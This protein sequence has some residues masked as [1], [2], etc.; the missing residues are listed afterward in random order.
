MAF[1]K[2][3]PNLQLSSLWLCAKG[4]KKIIISTMSRSNKVLGPMFCFA[5]S[6][7]ICNA[8]SN[9]AEILISNMSECSCFMKQTYCGKWP[10]SLSPLTAVVA[11]GQCNW[12]FLLY[13]YYIYIVEMATLPIRTALKGSLDLVRQGSL[14][15]FE[16][17]RH[18]T[19]DWAEKKVTT[20][21]QS[22]QYTERSVE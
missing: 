4:R 2:L 18:T 21:R 14:D 17:V 15:P 16:K 8:S 22:K 19:E 3:K 1:R 9:N 5:D 20:T 11:R 7:K 6:S 13:I 12:I 10:A